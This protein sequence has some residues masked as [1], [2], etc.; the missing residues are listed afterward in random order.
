M[1]IVFYLCIL[2]V[3]I[4]RIISAEEIES[5]RALLLELFQKEPPK[6]KILYLLRAQSHSNKV[7]HHIWSD[8]ETL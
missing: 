5:F 2:C 4:S 3:V 6:H 1:L 7:L 8:A